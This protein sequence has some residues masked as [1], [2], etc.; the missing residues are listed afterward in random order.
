[1][2][3]PLAALVVA[4]VLGLHALAAA[5][6]RRCG[7]PDATGEGRALAALGLLA[8][9]LLAVLAVA[10]ARRLEDYQSALTI[11]RD[12]ARLRPD[13]PRARSQLGRE[14]LFAGQPGEALAELTAAME[15]PGCEIEA[16]NNAGHALA[17]LGRHEDAAQHF[18]EL[19]RADAAI[20][21]AQE[22]LG[23]AAIELERWAEAE[24]ALRQCLALGC[25]SANVLNNLGKALFFLGRGAEA[26]QVFEQAL[27]LEP[28]HAGATANL[29]K[30]RELL[31]QA[32]R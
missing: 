32:P 5:A 23:I 26:V 19:L 4:A 22:G 31:E 25:G 1:M 13:N 7:G 20:C 15:L 9:P 10:T 8:L 16:F 6:T 14:L 3:L 24:A 18:R 29:A 17:A 2:Y 28:G 12:A 11:W 27:A 30:V 21:R